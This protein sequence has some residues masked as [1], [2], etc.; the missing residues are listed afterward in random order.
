MKHT[1]SLPVSVSS[2]VSISSIPLCNCFEV[3]D[4]EDTVCNSIHMQNQSMVFYMDKDTSSGSTV[5]DVSVQ[6]FDPD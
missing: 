2:S 1:T 6:G 5:P 3:L 4:M